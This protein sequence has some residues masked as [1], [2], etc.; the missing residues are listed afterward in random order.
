V[1]AVIIEQSDLYVTYSLNMILEASINA[2]LE[3]HALLQHDVSIPGIKGESIKERSNDIQ[4][5]LVVAES[6]V[7]LHNQIFPEACAVCYN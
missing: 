6:L 2:D 4:F 3:H 5:I 7:M 1:L